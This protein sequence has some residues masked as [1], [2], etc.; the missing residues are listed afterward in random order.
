L[1]ASVVEGLPLLS[2]VSSGGPTVPLTT[3]RFL[4]LGGMLPSDVVVKTAGFEQLTGRVDPKYGTVGWDRA[5]LHSTS[6]ADVDGAR[7]L[8]VTVTTVPLTRQVPGVTV[9]V[10]VVPVWLLGAKAVT[11]E[12][13]HGPVAVV[14]VVVE[15]VKGVVKLMSSKAFSFVGFLAR[16][17][18]S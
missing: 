4:A 3:W 11:G 6:D 1:A 15:V 18:A 7:L 16:P 2:V 10:A 8:A 13:M 5:V 14:V 17:L 12:G 9:N